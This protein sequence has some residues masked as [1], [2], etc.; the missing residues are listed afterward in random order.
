MARTWIYFQQPLG[1]LTTGRQN[2]EASAIRS[3]SV[4]RS[5]RTKL[6][7]RHRNRNNQTSGWHRANR[8]QIEIAQG[9]SVSRGY[10][11]SFN[12]GH[13]H[14]CT[15]GETKEGTNERCHSFMLIAGAYGSLVFCSPGLN[16]T[17]CRV[18]SAQ[19]GVAQWGNDHC[20]PVDIHPRTA[21]NSGPDRWLVGSYL[22]CCGQLQSETA[23]TSMGYIGT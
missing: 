7:K 20:T 4:E 10:T 9:P 23:S 13:L 21:S 17:V 5:Q 19:P 12:S 11:L 14:A 6:R 15:V 18:I 3:V 2:R 22:C 1:R 8:N 16:A